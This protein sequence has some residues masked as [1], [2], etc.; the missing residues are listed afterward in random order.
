MTF[1]V[2]PQYMI[3]LFGEAFTADQQAESLSGIAELGF[4]AFQPELFHPEHLDGWVDGGAAAVAEAARRSGVA[5]SQLVGH[6]LLHGFKDAPSLYSDWGIEEASRFATTASQFDGCTVVTLPL[7]A[8]AWGEEERP[9][10][11]RARLVEKLAA[12]AEA[13][14]EA[15]SRLALEI[16][17][18]SLVI[19]SGA[20]PELLRRLP[21]GVGHNFDTGPAWARKERVELIPQLLD[22]NILGTHLCDN[23]SHE[24]RSEPPGR[25]SI[26]WEPTLRALLEAGYGGSFDLEIRTSPEDVESD[27]REG[28]QLLQSYLYQLV[29]E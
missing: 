29:G 12:V 4:S 19:G 22:G 10:A 16:M 11:L 6:F 17:P 20:L 23:E 25:G 7:P 15:G 1:G 2:S 28:L 13:V 3:S 18:F 27:Y 5:A 26:P 24:N 14:G 21:G 8:F 9:A